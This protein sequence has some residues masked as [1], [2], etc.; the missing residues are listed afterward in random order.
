MLLEYIIE[1][2]PLKFLSPLDPI[3]LNILEFLKIKN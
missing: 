1:I 2:P 3:K